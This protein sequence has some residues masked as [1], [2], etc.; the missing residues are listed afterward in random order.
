MVQ[1]ILVSLILRNVFILKSMKRVAV[2]FSGHLRNFRLDNIRENFINVLLKNDCIVDYFFSL[3]DTE[4]HRMLNFSGLADINDV[5]DILKPK[6]ILI[7]KFDR[8]YFIEKYKSNKWMEYRHLSNHTT[9]GDSVSMW[10]KIQSTLDMVERYQ[11]RYGFE[12]DALCRVRSD[13]LFDDVFE[14]EVLDEVFNRDVL[15][16]PKWSGKWYEVSHTITDYFGIGNYKVM[17]KYMS[18]FNNIEDLISCNLYPHTGEGFL[19]QQINGMDIKRLNGGF[20]VQR[21]DH[22]EKIV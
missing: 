14:K 4:G 17:K 10:Y 2:T 18:V 15:F 22:I 3:W 19:C 13:V 11:E 8:E 9:C 6:G 20:S 21:S 12:Y 5:L 1:W 16:I 7:E